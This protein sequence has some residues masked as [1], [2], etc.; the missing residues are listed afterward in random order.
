MDYE[1]IGID[2]NISSGHNLEKIIEAIDKLQVCKGW[3]NPVESENFAN[4]AIHRDNEGFLRYN[5]AETIS[6][7][8]QKK[9]DENEKKMEKDTF[10]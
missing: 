7:K 9:R 4:S 3:A 10:K 5:T 1:K 2:K 8:R 6:R